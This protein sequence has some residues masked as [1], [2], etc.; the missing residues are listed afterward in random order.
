MNP[1]LVDKNHALQAIAEFDHLD[2]RAPKI[3]FDV[4]PIER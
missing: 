1:K 3:V 4:I 2:V